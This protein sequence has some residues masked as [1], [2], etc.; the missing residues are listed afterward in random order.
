LVYSKSSEAIKF[1]K[2]EES[3]NLKEIKVKDIQSY[4]ILPKKESSEDGAYGFVIESNGKK[5]NFTVDDKETFDR[6]TQL[7]DSLHINSKKN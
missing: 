2:G 7:L 4:T 1:S 5:H 6:W 3:S